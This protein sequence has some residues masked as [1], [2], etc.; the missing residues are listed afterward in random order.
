MRLSGC[1]MD[2]LCVV[3]AH[4]L[5]NERNGVMSSSNVVSSGSVMD[6]VSLN[7]VLVKMSTN[8]LGTLMDLLDLMMG[9]VMLSRVMVGLGGGVWVGVVHALALIAM[10]SAIVASHVLLG[11]VRVTGVVAEHGLTIGV[12]VRQIGV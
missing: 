12:T 6:G 1:G 11:V 7:V 10:L 3:G 5:V 9:C 4:R 2:G 8:S